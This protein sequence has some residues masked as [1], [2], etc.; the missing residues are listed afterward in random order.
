MLAS[1]NFN[2]SDNADLGA[3]WDVV[4][5]EDSFKIVSNQ[6]VPNIVSNDAG[7]S[8]NSVTWPNDQYSKVKCTETS[9]SANIGPGVLI[10]AAVG[11]RTYYRTVISSAGSANV[12]IAKFVAGTYTQLATRT[13]ALISGDLLYIEARANTLLVKKNGVALGAT[14]SDSAITAG[15]PGISYSSQGTAP[16]VDDWEGGNLLL[17]KKTFVRQAVNRASTY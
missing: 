16:S 7:E 14:I 4:T 6:V 13:S 9:T 12:E 15:R 8:N 3:N 17:A 10:R 11:A 1:D 2:R 5:G